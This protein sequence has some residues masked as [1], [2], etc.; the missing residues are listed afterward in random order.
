M[1]PITPISSNVNARGGRADI[2]MQI[3][4]QANSV[5]RTFE[6]MP[7]RKTV[8]T[9]TAAVAHEM[10]SMNKKRKADAIPYESTGPRKQAAFNSTRFFHSRIAQITISNKKGTAVNESAPASLTKSQPSNPI[11]L[12]ASSNQI[13][14]NNNDVVCGS[15]KSINDLVGNKRFRVWIDLHSKS[16]AKAPRAEHRQKIA[17]SIVNT[18]HA[19][20][21]QGRFLSMDP[22]TGSWYVVGHERAVGI[23]LEVLQRETINRPVPTQVQSSFPEYKR[24]TFA[25]MAA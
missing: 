6:N 1:F 10:A 11:T 20:V 15:G 8:S 3:A 19:C 14:V 16:F 9:A 18:I 25:S 5:R 13:Q 24:K 23:V 12:N 2:M 4:H 7:T 21:P 17:G 22:H